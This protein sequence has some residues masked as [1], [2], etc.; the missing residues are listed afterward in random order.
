MTDSIG[1]QSSPLSVSL[2]GRGNDIFLHWMANCKGHDKEKLIYSF[3]QGESMHDQMRADICH[4]LFGSQQESTLLALL[5]HNESTEAIIYRYLCIATPPLSW[6][7]FK[8]NNRWTWP[9][10]QGRRNWGCWGCYSTPN[11]SE[12]R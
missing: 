2:R 1:S 5:R 10:F 3:P 6:G 7:R 11:I 9:N 8:F 12:N 4:S